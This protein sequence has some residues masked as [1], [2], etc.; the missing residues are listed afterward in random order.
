MSEFTGI[1][2]A[3]QVAETLVGGLE[4][5]QKLSHVGGD[6]AE[7]SLAAIRAALDALGK[8][9]AQKV[10]PQAALAHIESLHAAVEANDAAAVAELHARFAK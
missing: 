8:V 6:K 1:R 2:T 4:T 9:T 3:L 10:T 5:L 7:T